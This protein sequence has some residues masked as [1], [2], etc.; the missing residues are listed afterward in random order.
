LFLSVCYS[1][2]MN[3]LRSNA[4][5]KNV[6]A[7][8]VMTY[9]FCL[10]MSMFLMPRCIPDFTKTLSSK[11]FSINKHSLIANHSKENF[12]RITDRSVLDDDPLNLV[13]TIAVVF[14]IIFGGILLI[15]KKARFTP[16]QFYQY[17]NKQYSYLSLRTIRI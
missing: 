5:F 3:K 12:I 16:H 2:S 10:S 11:C 4:L 14:L 9:I 8:F 15:S 17:Y 13:K 1:D 6:V 7:I